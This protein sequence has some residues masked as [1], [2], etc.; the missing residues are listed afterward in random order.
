MLRIVGQDEESLDRITDW[1]HDL[2]YDWP[3]WPGTDF[4]LSDGRFCLELVDQE[5]FLNKEAVTTFRL[6]IHNVDSLEVKGKPNELPGQEEFNKFVYK[7][8]ENLLIL[9]NCL[10]TEIWC[11]VRTL[12]VVLEQLT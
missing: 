2:W 10:T 12:H 11:T 5:G 3:G 9:K 1:I 6:C 4:E 7:P 8:R